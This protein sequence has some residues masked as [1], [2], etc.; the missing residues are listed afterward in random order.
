MS[1]TLQFVDHTPVK[2]AT[3][4]P[5]DATPSGSNNINIIAG[6]GGSALSGEE[7][8]PSTFFG[9][10]VHHYNA[11]KSYKDE[12]FK[13]MK[14]WGEFFDR[15][16]FSAPGKMEAFSRA[17]KNVSYFYSNYVVLATV[18]SLYV[19]L[20]NPS[21]LLCMFAA[22]G[23]YFFLRM[24]TNANEPIM[25]VTK[26][27][28]YTQAWALLIVFSIASFYITGGSSTVFCFHRWGRCWATQCFESH[29]RMRCHL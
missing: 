29:P 12:R 25:I 5:A 17:N 24:K 7:E 2:N 23:M 26:E 1:D 14:P 18:S 3:Y 8:A 21:F 28:S 27:I 15:A 9:K 6:S 10:V 16:K 4:V 13:T 11:I 19:L 22:M 20:I